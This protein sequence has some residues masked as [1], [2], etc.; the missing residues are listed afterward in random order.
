[1]NTLFNIIPNKVKQP[2]Q[3]CIHCGKNYV[4]KSNLDKH[5]IACDL[6]QKS[7]ERRKIPLLEEI[8]D[9]DQQIPSQKK[10]FQMLIELGIK[11]NKLEEK[12]DEISKWVVKKKKKINMIE[13]LNDNIIPTLIFDQLIDKII[14]TEEDIEFLFNNSFYDTLNN[15][16]SKTIYELSENESPICTFIQKSNI[17]YVYIG[18]TEKWCEISR[19]Q[20]IKF[21]NKIHMKVIKSFAD[22]KRTHSKEI[23][24]NDGLS[25]I[26][27]KTLV[28]I[29]SI[30]FK[31]DGTFNKVR[32]MIYNR[33][34]KDIKAFV[35]YEFEF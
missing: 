30:D 19:E 6:L 26:C 4:K 22:W 18:V 24:E 11:Y 28:K 3:C 33:M 13:W 16:F 10:L 29:M 12:V 14:I 34:K 31:I 35:E 27:D 7:K 20:F 21:L 25:I 2:A 5:M 23:K 15:V 8:S 17:L 32:S 1:M 9:E